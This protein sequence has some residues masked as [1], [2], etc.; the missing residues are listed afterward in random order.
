[1]NLPEIPESIERERV[2][3]FMNSI[4]VDPSTVTEFRL[5]TKGVYTTTFVKDERGVKVITR[6]GPALNNVFI[7]FV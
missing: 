2:V 3:E 5:D 6:D 4:G 7:R 1:M